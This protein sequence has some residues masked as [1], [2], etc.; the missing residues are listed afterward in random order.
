MSHV[1]GFRQA[2]GEDPRDDAVRLIYADWLDENGDP[3]RAEFIRV[4]CELPRL[5][6][7]HPRRAGLVLREQELLQAH[8]DEWWQELP[9]WAR[10]DSLGGPE[11]S[12]SRGFVAEV[13]VEAEAFLRGAEDLY[14]VAP[15]D[16]LTISRIGNWMAELAACPYLARLRDLCILDPIGNEGTCLLVA[17]PHLARLEEL[18]LAGNGIGP[19]GATA[20]SRSRFL[21]NLTSLCL[22]ENPLEDEGAIALAT[23]PLLT[24]LRKLWLGD[25]RVG[26][27]GALALAESTSLGHLTYLDLT[28]NPIAGE[29]AQALRDRFGSVVH[30]S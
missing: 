11:E 12:F 15:V 17:S 18:S 26:T 25:T 16:S 20:L 4:Q 3:E 19:S 13:L 7:N 28:V 6:K 1:D 5:G 24:R 23:S 8:L 30:L 22:E 14:R 21:A 9:P 10:E 29:A 27:S 2:I